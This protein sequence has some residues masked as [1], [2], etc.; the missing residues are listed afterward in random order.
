VNGEKLETRVAEAGL[1]LEGATL[2]AGVMEGLEPVTGSEEA[3]ASVD[4]ATLDAAG[5]EGK[6]GQTITLPH[7]D[8]RAVLLVGLGEEASF[9]SL[10]SASGNAIRDVKTDRAVTLLALVGIEGAT[11]AVVE[12]T[13]LGGYEFR[14]YKTSDDGLDAEVVDVV[15]GEEAELET[16]VI[17]CEATI[18][19][20][21]WVNTPAKD[22]SPETLAGLIEAATAGTGISVEV[23]D[24]P[25]IEEEK[26]G[27]LLGVAAGSDR[28]PR[29]V[30]LKYRPDDAESHLA[31]VGKGIVF[32]TG[33][34]SLKTAA[35]MEEM[36]DDMSGAA[37]VCAAVVGIAR[38]GLP[39][40]VTA[41]APL[42]DNAVGGDATRP[43][44]V[45]RPLE[46]PTIEVLNTD[47]EG[48]LILADGLALAK[49]FEPDLTIDVAT[50]TGAAA[51]A[52]GKQVAA[53]FGSDSD[54]SS[55]VLDAAARAGEEFWELPLFKGYR[56]SIDSNVADIK[57]I[58]SS[59]YGGA[60]VAAL[61]LAE[62][63][64][65]GPWAHLDIAGPARSAETTGE[66]VK[67]ASGVGVR[68]LIEVAHTMSEAD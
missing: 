60:I 32:D 55:R 57:N 7:P 35:N 64:G 12:G 58:S 10:R 39:V 29:V 41:I 66:F 1:D 65:E 27:A 16:A 52:L 13:L 48:R 49:R 56:K 3:V 63:A 22:K 62:Y 15:G 28:D 53:V 40:D 2:I 36:K 59:R 31:L 46:G 50:L 68:T 20:R 9:E 37:V 30:F 4:R 25:R 43:G 23:W 6:L 19:A 24:R 11:R 54:V 61:F 33:G 47:A 8:A 21:E 17:A 51:V 26:L 5:F 14:A 42:T 45:L 44:D 67:G 34:L 18:L 38:L